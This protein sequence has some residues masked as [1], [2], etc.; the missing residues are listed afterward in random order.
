MRLFSDPWESEGLHKRLTH[1]HQLLQKNT[2]A[3]YLRCQSAEIKFR[4][5]DPTDQL[6]DL[7]KKNKIM[8]EQTII[9]NKT[10]QK[11]DKPTQSFLDLKIELIY[12]MLTE[13]QFCENQCRVDR[14]Q[15]KAGICGILDESY[16][17]SSFLHHGEEKPLVPSGTI[18]FAGCSFDCVFCQNEDISTGGK[19]YPLR[20]A[21]RKIDAE[22]LADIANRLL[23]QGAININYV[24]GDPT[25]NLHTIVESLRFQTANI[26]QL[27]NSNFYNT[28]PVLEILSDLMDLWLPDLKYGNN[29]CG[30]RLSGVKNYWDILQRNFRYI[31]EHG[32]NNII[33]RHLVLPDHFECCTRPILEFIAKEIPQAVV[34]I[35]AQYHPEYKVSKTNYP[36][37]N[38][39]VSRVEMQQAFDLAQNLGIEFRSVS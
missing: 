3:L 15:G 31:S 26:C 11:L 16:I 7:H 14:T 30:K 12:R 6:W 32:S 20:S 33:I 36:E 22:G 18:F 25:P 38:R 23:N 9:A 13:C 19:T 4:K 5:E 2:T 10:S 17:S 28:L 35:M 24:G 1:Y 34:N 27:W 37:I 29:T 39:Q 21:G 8:L